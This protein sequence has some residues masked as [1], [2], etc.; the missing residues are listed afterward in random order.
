MTVRFI[1][2]P[3]GAGKTEC[4]IRELAAEIGRD[5]LGPPLL[6]LLPEQAT[7][8]HE[9]QLAAACP[10]GGFCR[11]EVS[12][13][14]RLVY[15]AYR[16][17]GG[18]PLAPLSEG[19][20]L[21][22]GAAV[23]AACREQLRILAPAAG[24]RGFAQQVM[25]AGEE[26]ATYGVSPDALDAAVEKLAAQAPTSQSVAKLREISLL[27]RA[28]RQDHDGTYGSYR[29]NMEFLAQTIEAGFL[30]DTW[31]WIDGYSQFTPSERQVIRGMFAVC[32]RVTVALPLDASQ[33]E[34][35]VSIDSPFYPAWREYAALTELAR[36]QG[37][38]VEPPVRLDG[39]R[40][41]FAQNGDLAAAHAWLV[42][43]VPPRTGKPDGLRLW[44]ATDR[45]EELSRVAREILRLCREEGLHF[46]DVGVFARDLEPYQALLP[47]VFDEI[48]V[49]YFLDAKKPLLYHPL[50]ELVRSVMEVW[51]YRPEP[52]RLL[53]FLKNRL[54][55]LWGEAGDRLENYL[56]RHGLRFW[57]W[58]NPDKPLPPP[59]PEE[60]VDGEQVESWRRQGIEPLLALCRELGD[61]C[62]APAFHQRLYQLFAELGVE[63]R[64]AD[65]TRQALERGDGEQAQWHQQAWN[66]LAGLLQEAEQILGTRV[67]A[68]AELSDLYEAAFS[69]LTLSTIPAGIDQVTIG[70]LERTYHPE[71]QAAFLLS[72][73]EGVLPRRVNESGLFRDEERRL[74]AQVQ[75][76]LA[77]DS[78][79]RQCG[80]NALLYQGLTR[81]GRRLYLSYLLHGD[82]GGELTPS[83]VVGD[84]QR[85]FPG[86][87]PEGCQ[88]DRASLLVGGTADLALCS[89]HLSRDR[90][91]PL[92]QA[93]YR[94]YQDQADAENLVR[95]VERG[96]TYGP[97]TRRLSRGVLQRW[98]GGRLYGSVT[99]LEQ[100]RCCPFAYFA[101]YGLKTKP[102][103]EYRI[104]A[105]DRGTLV[106]QALA[107]VG[108][109]VNEQGLDWAALDT[110][111]IQAMVDQV[112]DSLLP[113]FLS[114]ILDSSPRY[115]YLQSR[116]R[117]T[118]VQAIR[119]LTEQVRQSGFL[120]I[121]FELSFGGK[122]PGLPAFTV[123]VDPDRDLVLTGQIDRVDAAR[124]GERTWLRVVDYKT[125]KPTLDRR[126]VLA[127]LQ[128]QLLLYLQVV[129]AHGDQLS[130]GGPVSPAGAY[131]AYVR[132]DLRAANDPEEIPD[133]KL[134]GLTV[135]DQTGIELADAGL[136]TLA[137]A[138]RAGSSPLI[139]VS[140]DKTGQV[141]AS[142]S[143]IPPEALAQLTAALTAT[144][145]DTARAMLDGEIPVWPLLDGKHDTCRQ[146]S[147]RTVCG[148]DRTLA[149]SRTVQDLLGKEAEPWATHNLP[150]NK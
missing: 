12:G 15:R 49:P 53:R 134:A 105:P 57:H 37:V 106:H 55:P 123:P 51:T 16:R 7:F 44:A 120:P 20:K 29:E 96:L 95:Q 126:D 48:G 103:P 3:A 14:R 78:A 90:S 148:F 30:Q 119:L 71:L 26:L 113:G 130:G 147:Q 18:Q 94:H 22:L 40:G 144:L 59:D 10:G 32:P 88:V 131:Y 109:L 62:S 128:V 102:R 11:A 81:C 38:A 54:H 42:T 111:T 92:W 27:Y 34:Q 79:E 64:L 1:L 13:F 21:M 61:A 2:A 137:R 146:C 91:A 28:Y 150:Q 45:R 142:Q 118:L 5:P 93:V 39:S 139:P 70:S 132:D 127:G 33:A 122:G 110:E 99:R 9:R 47:A 35:V 100:Y 41:R 43:T 83:P 107:A 115:A 98:Y 101:T 31:V 52:R 84:L 24:K 108:R 75:V 135:L 89:A 19:G 17:T 36:E 60:G 68:A 138:E 66:R 125:G 77:P 87:H 112:L 129:M 143:C 114:G 58:Q 46:R 76:Y 82:D 63:E 50:L 80:E 116:L 23:T 86:L 6:F 141:K 117:R 133:L 72:L 25:A 149:P 104:T 85:V 74:L 65:L 136:A 67:Y 124:S 121:A 69:G 73:N 145:Q 4:C 140:F 97:S 56:L 8:V